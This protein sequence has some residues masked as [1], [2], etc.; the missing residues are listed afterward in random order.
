MAID[1][2]NSGVNSGGV[3]NVATGTFTGNGND[4][5]IELGFKPHYIFVLN[6]TDGVGWVKLGTMAAA[7]TF[8]HAAAANTVDTGSAITIVDEGAGKGAFVAVAAT[9]PNAKVIHWVAQG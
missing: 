1:I 5:R 6:E 9:V 4:K 7:N 8:K 3:V 2:I